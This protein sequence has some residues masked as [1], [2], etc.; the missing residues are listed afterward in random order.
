MFSIVQELMLSISG[1]GFVFVQRIKLIKLY[2]ILQYCCI[3][4]TYHHEKI[5]MQLFL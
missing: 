4:L 2:F 3:C 5:V 1:V